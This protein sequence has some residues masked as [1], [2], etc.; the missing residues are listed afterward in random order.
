M[1][2]AACAQRGVRKHAVRKLAALA[3]LPSLFTASAYFCALPRTM[4]R[5]MPPLASAIVPTD[6]VGQSWPRGTG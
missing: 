2:E 1:H 5:I 3:S 4:A 6:P